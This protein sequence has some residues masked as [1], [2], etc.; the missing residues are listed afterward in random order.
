VRYFK[1]LTP[2][3][4]LCLMTSCLIVPVPMRVGIRGPIKQEALTFLENG[5]A[6]REEVILHLGMPEDTFQDERIFDYKWI[7]AWDIGVVGP[8]GSGDWKVQKCNILRFH[9]DEH[10]I[11]ENLYIHSY[12]PKVLLDSNRECHFDAT[13]AK[14]LNILK[15]R[16]SAD[17]TFVK[18]RQASCS[19]Y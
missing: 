16:V 9:F 5:P 8:A 18:E 3:A 1:V 7:G 15:E 4:I 19:P 17:H 14:K 2:I 11:V 12:K 10:G 6:T 13:A